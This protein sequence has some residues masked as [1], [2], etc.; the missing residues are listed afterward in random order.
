MAKALDLIPAPKAG[1]MFK[2]RT[3]KINKARAAMYGLFLWVKF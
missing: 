1:L 2:F 3:R